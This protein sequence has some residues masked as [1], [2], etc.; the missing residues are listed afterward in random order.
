MI[1]QHCGTVQHIKTIVCLANPTTR[2]LYATKSSFK[3]HVLSQKKPTL[4]SAG[5]AAAAHAYINAAD[6]GFPVVG[7]PRNQTHKFRC[8]PEITSV[9]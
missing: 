6:V 5:S 3:F 4:N 8:H 2:G 9:A 7:G 1:K